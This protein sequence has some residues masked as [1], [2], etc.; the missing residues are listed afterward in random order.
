MK[1]SLELNRKED[2]ELSEFLADAF[3][4]NEK[5]DIQIGDIYLG[6]PVVVMSH[7]VSMTAEIQLLDNFEMITVRP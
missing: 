2:K 4:S 3:L 1:I 6:R 7:S 5:F